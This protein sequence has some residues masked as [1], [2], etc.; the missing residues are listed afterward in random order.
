MYNPYSL[1]WFLE[2]SHLFTHTIASYRKLEHLQGTR[3]PKYYVSFA[4]VVPSG[5]LKGR[6][7]PVILRELIDGTNVGELNEEVYS[8]ETQQL[9]MEEVIAAE[10][11]LDKAGVS[12]AFSLSPDVFILVEEEA[13][14]RVVVCYF[15]YTALDPTAEDIFSRPRGLPVVLLKWKKALLEKYKFDWLVDWPWVPWLYEKYRN[16]LEDIYVTDRLVEEAS[17]FDKQIKWIGRLDKQIEWVGETD[18]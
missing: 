13:K 3:I 1:G 2:W 16:E 14:F 11:E 9:I 17:G 7:I 5:M 15:A 12:L 10:R 6:Q 18:H 4:M 8:T